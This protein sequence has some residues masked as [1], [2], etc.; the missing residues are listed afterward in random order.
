MIFRLYLLILFPLWLLYPSFCPF[1]RNME[2]PWKYEDLPMVCC[3]GR[4]SWVDLPIRGWHHQGALMLKSA[5]GDSSFMGFLLI[6]PEKDRSSNLELVEG[7][8]FVFESFSGCCPFLDWYS[9]YM[10]QYGAFLIMPE[11]VASPI[12]SNLLFKN[13]RS[14]GLPEG[15]SRNR[16]FSRHSIDHWVGPSWRLSVGDHSDQIRGVKSWVNYPEN[17]SDLRTLQYLFKFLD[18]HRQSPCFFGVDC[19]D[20]GFVSSGKQTCGESNSPNTDR[21][22]CGWIELFRISGVQWRFSGGVGPD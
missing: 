9:W 20:R 1:E 2:V 21:S 19:V 10:N 12:H 16:S 22:T 11:S 18:I 4:C 14:N 13:Q 6:N 8:D 17:L 3:L 5:G 7:L 15:R